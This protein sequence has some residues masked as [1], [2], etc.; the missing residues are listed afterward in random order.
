MVFKR[1]KSRITKKG[2]CSGTGKRRTLQKQFLFFTLAISL[3]V[4]LL[5]L[6]IT[7]F[8]SAYTMTETTAQYLSA[9]IKYADD[10]FKTNLDNA[11][12]LVYA[13]ASDREIVQ[14]TIQGTTVEASYNW[15]VEQ[16]R[17]RSYLDGMIVD[18]VYVTR[19]AV[20]LTNGLIYQSTGE[21]LIQKDL[22][23]DW[24][25]KALESSRLQIAYLTDTP[26]TMRINRPILRGRENVGVV[27]IELNANM[28][29]NA[30]RL[31]PLA[32]VNLFVFTPEGDLLYSQSAGGRQLDPNQ[33]KT[34]NTGYN[35]LGGDDYYTLR[36]VGSSGLI[37]TGLVQRADFVGNSVAL[38]MRIFWVAL[39]AFVLAFGA[40]RLLA[41]YLFRNLN[42]LMD[43]MRAVRKGEV[44]RRAVLPNQDEISDAGDAFNRM[45]NQLEELMKSIRLEE[46]A[47]REA[48]QN[49]LAAQIQ[50]HFIYNSI[51]AIRYMAQMN[52]QEDIEAAARAL[53]DLMRSVLGNRDE[54][55]TL[56]EER[57]YIEDYIVLQRFKYQSGFSLQWDVDE[58]LWAMRIPKLLLQP[59]VENAL[60]HGIPVRADGEIVVSAHEESSTVTIHVTDNG[61]GMDEARVNTLMADHPVIPSTLRKFGLDNVRDRVTL[62]YG[63]AASFRIISVKDSF[64]CVE[65][66]LPQTGGEVE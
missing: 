26:G 41:Q 34:V 29:C 8:S 22:S 11:K 27:F 12:L 21:M 28:M 2:F 49:V 13:I 47:K 55:I 20:V 25:R 53:G 31:Q 51:S 38:G 61:K 14:Q 57:S 18:K 45:M 32:D 40:S 4:M 52:G 56:W 64:T 5:T 6:G 23:T 39:A 17:M 24:Y 35:Q 16:K 50:P 36:Y 15:F 10:S 42:I 33:V 59:L 62:C 63:K 30:Y 54:W 37:V 66:I 58:P 48:E 19:L 44:S 3:F 7:Y 65:L 1:W 9:Y 60:I 43:C 46:A